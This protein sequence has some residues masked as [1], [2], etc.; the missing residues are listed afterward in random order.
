M[1]F[2]PPTLHKGGVPRTKTTHK[3]FAK[4]GRRNTASHNK[5]EVRNLACCR[6]YQ[7]S[8]TQDTRGYGGVQFICRVPHAPR[9]RLTQVSVRFGTA[10]LVSPQLS[11]LPPAVIRAAR[12]AGF[13]ST[14]P[15]F[16]GLPRTS[17]HGA[18]TSTLESHLDLPILSSCRLRSTPRLSSSAHDASNPSSRGRDERFCLHSVSWCRCPA[19]LFSLSAFINRKRTFS[20]AS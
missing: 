7:R 15:V 14:W 6:W 12:T 19:G 10:L 3:L 9:T 20:I 16:S 17:V 11:T 13:N 1:R 8:V 5:E 4:N 2:Q 18:V